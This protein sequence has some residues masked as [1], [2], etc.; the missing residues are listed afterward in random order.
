MPEPALGDRITS[1]NFGASSIPE[2][3]SEEDLAKKGIPMSTGCLNDT[4]PVYPARM[5]LLSEK[6]PNPVLV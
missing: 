4:E 1:W 2:R 3:F 5:L 6:I